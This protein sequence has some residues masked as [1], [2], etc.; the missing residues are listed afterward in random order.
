ME[1]LKSKGKNLGEHTVKHLRNDGR[2]GP[3]E[4]IDKKGQ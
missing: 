3:V 1:E 4:Y 2:F